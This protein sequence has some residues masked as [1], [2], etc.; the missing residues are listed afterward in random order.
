MITITIL[1]DNIVFQGML[2]S[3]WG[4]S[5]LVQAAGQTI[6]FDTGAD[7]VILLSNMEK[8]NI[9]PKSI[10]SV[11]ISHAHFDHTGGLSA[12][13][14]VNPDVTVYCPASF[15]GIRKAREVVYAKDFLKLDDDIYSTG[16]VGGIEQSLALNTPEGVIL[17]VGCAH[18]GMENIIQSVSHLGKIRAVIGGFHGLKNFKIFRNVQYICP[19]HCTW[20][21]AQIKEK[22][23]DKILKGGAGKVL[24]FE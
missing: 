16:E 11:F 21:P 19:T 14:N 13:L 22:Y 17:V 10:N 7:G 4:F 12:F 3:D 24:H 6:L 23:P 20:H 2:Q 9:D 15:R 18:A 1:Y 8:L 5:C